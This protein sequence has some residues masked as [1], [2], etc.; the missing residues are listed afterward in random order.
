MEKLKKVFGVIWKW[1]KDNWLV[2]VVAIVVI[3]VGA[4][5]TKSCSR[6]ESYRNLFREFREQS[7]D[8]QR[9]IKD[10]RGLQDLER[11]ERERILQEY[12]DE[13]HRIEREYKI[14]L[15]NIATQRNNT[16]D[17]II[18][19]HQRDPVTL[20]ETIRNAFGIPVLE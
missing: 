14:E 2:V 12:I 4:L 20:V 7:E 3:G 6:D 9:Q 17:N 18:N 16:Q 10:L 19:N 5:A 11:A 15:E 13:L 1:L 8:H